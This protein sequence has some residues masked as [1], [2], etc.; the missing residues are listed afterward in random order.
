[1]LLTEAVQAL[2]TQPDGIYVDG[3]FGRGGHARALLALLAPGG[4][5]VA[6][7][8][9]PEA[10]AAAAADPGPALRDLP[11]QLRRHG[12]DL[13][14]LGITR[15]QGVLLDLGVS[16]PQIDNPERGFSFRHDAPLDMRMDTTRGET[17][18]DFLQRADQRQIEEV[19]RELWRRTVCCSDCKGACRSPRKRGSRAP[20]RGAFRARGSC[21]QNP[22]A[23]PGPCNA[24]ISSSSDSCQRRA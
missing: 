16:S 14:A 2:V 8:K 23:G 22:R 20:H 21:S 13:A 24:H 9:D 6:F 18:A 15:V 19:I 4:R 1:V 3:T 5:L 10:V 7:D 11:R 17:A 12:V